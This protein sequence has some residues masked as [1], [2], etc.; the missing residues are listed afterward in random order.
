[1][2]PDQRVLL[3]EKDKRPTVIVKGLTAR[4]FRKSMFVA[5]YGNT[6]C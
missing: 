5:K 1:M 3:V 2:A 6:M 4:Y